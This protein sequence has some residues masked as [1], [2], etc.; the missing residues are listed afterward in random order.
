MEKLAGKFR[1]VREDI[2]HL[3]ETGLTLRSDALS[4]SAMTRYEKIYKLNLR[5]SFSLV[6]QLINFN[7][8]FFMK[9]ID[10]C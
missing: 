5:I 3:G 1:R 9:H 10:T 7:F 8:R 4:L 2:M 6:C